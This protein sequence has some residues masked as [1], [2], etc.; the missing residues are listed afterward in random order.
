MF[1]AVIAIAALFGLSL[2]HAQ[3]AA[4]GGKKE[5]AGKIV[6]LMKPALEGLGQQ[7]A[8]QPAQQIQQRAFAALQ[9]VP[10]ERREVVAREIEADLRKYVEDTTPMVRDRAVKLAP[11]TLSPMLEEKFTEDELRQIVQFLESPLNR[12]FQQFFPEMQRALAEKL[13]AELRPDIETKA[14]ALEQT[15]AKRLGVPSGAAAPAPAPAPKK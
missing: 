7:L 15:V 10:A 2:V 11:A 9:S 1:R 6:V 3:T 12:R 13:V 14:R 8:Q 5:Q 4:P